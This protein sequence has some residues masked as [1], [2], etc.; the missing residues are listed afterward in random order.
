MDITSLPE[1]VLHCVGSFLCG[2]EKSLFGVAISS[3]SAIIGNDQALEHLD[4]VDIDPELAKRLTD[5]DLHNILVTIDAVNTVKVLKLTNCYGMTGAGLEPL[6][7]S[8]VL[9]LLDLS[10]VSRHENPRLEV[11]T[12][13]SEAAVI[14]ILDSI[15]ERGEESTLR[16]VQFAQKW[17]SQENSEFIWARFRQLIINR[18]GLCSHC[19]NQATEFECCYQCLQLHLYC[20]FVCRIRSSNQSPENIIDW[21]NHCEKYLCKTCIPEWQRCNCDQLICGGCAQQCPRCNDWCC[22]RCI[23]IQCEICNQQVCWDCDW[24]PTI[25][26]EI[27]NQIACGHCISETSE[28]CNRDLCNR[29]SSLRECCY[30]DSEKCTICVKAEERKLGHILCD[31]FNNWCCPRCTD[32]IS[33]KHFCSRCIE[34]AERWSTEQTPNKKRKGD[35]S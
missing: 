2:V 7:G 33:D 19:Q 15:I 11:E 17:E 23:D 34:R 22:P 27:C 25:R 1:T 24:G 29:C 5:D 8:T 30:C 14:P 9:K 4:F 12:M 20:S 32:K 16:Y 31:D 18:N 28:C 10:L 13:I 3:W 21:C 6:R 35:Q 26:C